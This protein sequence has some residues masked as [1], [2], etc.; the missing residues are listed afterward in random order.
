VV[1]TINLFKKF[2]SKYSRCEESRVSLNALKP[3]ETLSG[4]RGNRDEAMKSNHINPHK[5]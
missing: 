3:D 2:S 5:S 4:M 1:A